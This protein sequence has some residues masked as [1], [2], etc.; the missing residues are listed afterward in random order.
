MPPAL[1]DHPVAVREHPAGCVEIWELS[2]RVASS[3]IKHP[4]MD[5]LRTHPR[6]HRAVRRCAAVHRDPGGGAWAIL[7]AAAESPAGKLID[8]GT[9]PY[10]TAAQARG[11]RR[12]ERRIRPTRSAA[13]IGVSRC[14]TSSP[15]AAPRAGGGRSGEKFICLW[16]SLSPNL[17]SHFV[18]SFPAD[19]GQ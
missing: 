1:P 18:T 9:S 19:V 13:G 15:E 4:R 2:K 17:M 7:P 5:A 14:G 11:V 6:T 16:T 8:V 3:T 10:A 12:C